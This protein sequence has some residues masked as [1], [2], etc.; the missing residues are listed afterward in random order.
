LE[1][2]PRI[3]PEQSLTV[4]DATPLR[5]SMVPSERD[6]DRSTATP[7]AWPTTDAGGCPVSV[8]VPVSIAPP[9]P[10]VTA[11]EPAAVAPVVSEDVRVTA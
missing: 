1:S 3:E 7:V 11:Y 10:I 9:S 6:A 2:K 5:E 4:D 8:S